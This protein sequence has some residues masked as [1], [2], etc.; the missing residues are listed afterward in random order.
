MSITVDKSEFKKGLTVA[1]NALP[2]KPLQVERGH[3]ICRVKGDRIFFEGTNS[4]LESQIIINVLEN[5]YTEDISFTLDPSVINKLISKIDYEKLCIEYDKSELTVK[6]YTS[7]DKQSFNT[8]QSFPVSKMLIID[9][10]N[11]EEL[12]K[13]TIETEVLKK[14]ISFCSAYLDNEDNRQYDFVIINKGVS[15]GANG[16]NRMGFF[17]ATELKDLENLK[18]RKNIISEVKSIL[19]SVTDEKIIIAETDNKTI[20]ISDET[21]VY[22]SFLKSTIPT[23]KMQL[24]FLKRSGP[25]TKTKH[26]DLIK[27]I[28]R[29]LSTRSGINLMS[30]G[31]NLKLSGAGANSV[32]ELSLMSN[33]KAKERISCERVDDNSDE[34][35]THIIHANLFQKII[36]SFKSDIINLYINTESPSFKICDIVEED[37]KKFMNVAVGSFSRVQKKTV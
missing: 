16:A 15:F 21:K 23:P 25:Y 14:A 4:D 12:P 26:S 22:F 18:I 6:I 29:L 19:S 28:Q 34:D 2:K 9:P 3:L 13:K 27:S 33:L 36:E 37:G 24:D 35:I 32:I 30:S 11:I 17:V 1:A 8:T 20:I 31:I 10:L 5:E 7:E